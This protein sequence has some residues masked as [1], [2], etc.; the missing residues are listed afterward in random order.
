MRI[1]ELH[2]SEFGCFKEKTVV[3][4]DGMNIV[5]GDNETGKSTLFLF[6]KFMLYGLTRRS[7]SSSDRERSVSWD[8]HR[9]SGSMTIEHDGSNYRIE[10]N[11]VESGRGGSEKLTI[12]CLDDG[13][14]LSTDKSPGELFLGVP[15]EVFESSAYVEQMS[16]SE[17]DGEKTAA[18]IENMLCTA[19]E[20]V[21]TA[22]ILKTLNDIRI[23]Y[24]HK[25]DGKGSLYDEEKRINELRIEAERAREEMLLLTEK[26][27]KLA[28]SRRDVETAR[29]DFEVA[30]TLLGEMNKVSVLKRFG[31]LRSMQA[32]M[33]SLSKELCSL[34]NELF[35]DGYEIGRDHIAELKITAREFAAAQKLYEEKKDAVSC[36]GKNVYDGDAARIGEKIEADGGKT[37]ILQKADKLNEK[38]KKKK[39]MRTLW[40]ILG[41]V[42]SC[43][44][45]AAVYFLGGVAALGFIG[46]AVAVF[47]TVICSISVRSL[48][49]EFVKNAEQ[50]GANA[51]NLAGH[52]EYCMS[53]LEILRTEAQKKEELELQLTRAEEELF[54]KKK[55]LQT[56]FSLTGNGSDVGIEEVASEFKRL[57]TLIS[58]R[59]TLES[60]IDA[61]S[62]II[63]LENE[64]L[65]HYDEQELQGQITLN[66]E[67][68]TDSAIA[69]AE[70]TRSFHLSRLKAGEERVSML[71]NM[72]M[73]LRMGAKDPLPLSDELAAL[74]K[75]HAENNEFYEALILAM[76]SIESASASMR[77]NVTPIISKRAGEILSVVSADRY[78]VMRT[79]NSFGFSLDKDGYS[80]KSELLS[81]GTRDLAY[82]ALR[83]SLFMRIY[84]NGFPPI[85]LDESLCQLDDGR[86]GRVLLFLYG[87]I[88]NGIQTILLT[89]HSREVGLCEENG[90]AYKHISL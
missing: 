39:G 56:V 32:E 69:S 68:V 55:A 50:Y 10:R 19:D 22:K 71:E 90:V 33:D 23:T 77:S 58:R 14:N 12:I 36:E 30:D 16:S 29:H 62:R 70:K 47:A 5:S 44:S 83:F 6:I 51:E 45:A 85:L 2:I 74:E 81:S 52:L 48:R 38:I 89:S 4:G 37:L 17:I 42:S 57:E 72:V 21:D 9:A 67:E 60:K 13:K 78:S 18:S 54:Q 87:L 65:E 34:Q 53:Q 26:E 3:F 40:I 7:S 24:K 43:A 76:S 31:K 59:E 41:A 46:L 73:G 79:T 25:S 20:S 84:D 63:R 82:L 75:K 64:T 27:G 88:Q 86:T 80:V 35:V 8:G 28:K 11:F 49:A 1:S 15:R 66:P 61:L